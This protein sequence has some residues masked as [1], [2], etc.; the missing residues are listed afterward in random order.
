MMLPTLLC[1]CLFLF[2]F[3][4]RSEAGGARGRRLWLC[5]LLTPP[6][7]QQRLNPVLQRESKHS[8][9]LLLGLCSLYLGMQ[10]TR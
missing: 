7:L 9:L 6:L 10:L 3:W 4:E 1:L 5:C 8:I 2:M